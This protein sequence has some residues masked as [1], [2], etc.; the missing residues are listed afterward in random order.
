MVGVRVRRYVLRLDLRLY[1]VV[2]R[3]R[4]RIMV[5]WLGLDGIKV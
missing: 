5:L 2:V 1:R 4:V 3:I